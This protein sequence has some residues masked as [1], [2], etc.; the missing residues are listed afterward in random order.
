MEKGRFAGV[1][2][3][4]PP[5]VVVFGQGLGSRGRLPG[6]LEGSCFTQNP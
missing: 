1:G 2:G 3:R 5:E 6:V 4:V